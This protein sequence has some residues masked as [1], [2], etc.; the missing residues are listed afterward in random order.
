MATAPIHKHLIIRAEVE[1][2]PGK[3]DI[4]RMIDWTTELID[5]IDMKLLDGPFCKYVDIEGNSG[6]TVVAIIETS[7][8]AM[9]VWDEASPALMQLDV[10]T[11]GPFKPILVFEKLQ[12]LGLTKLE[13]KYLDRET[14]LKIEHIGSWNNNEGAKLPNHVILNN[15]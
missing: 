3:N 5:E 1:D 2:P 4:Q 8:V 9:H 14:K 11:C 6:L 15:G 12:D 10:Y 7:H 13:W